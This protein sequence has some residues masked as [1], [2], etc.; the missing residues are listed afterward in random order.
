MINKY[1]VMPLVLE[2]CPSF[3]RKWTIERAGTID[4]RLNDCL[5]YVD[6]GELSMHLIQLHQMKQ[7]DEYPAVFTLIERFLSEGDDYV[8]EAV[9]VGLFESLRNLAENHQVDLRILESFLHTDSLQWWKRIS[10]FLSKQTPAQ[11]S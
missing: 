2:A 5:L 3:K 9:T 8:K 4:E 11:Q 7:V 10:D 6:L 1:H